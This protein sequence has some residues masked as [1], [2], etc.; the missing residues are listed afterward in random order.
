MSTSHLNRLINNNNLRNNSL[1]SEHPME[2][3]YSLGV[4]RV[5]FNTK[6]NVLFIMY[7][8]SSFRNIFEIH[9]CY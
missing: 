6:T 9:D 4:L 5:F 8:L 2:I 7:L 3:K 1:T